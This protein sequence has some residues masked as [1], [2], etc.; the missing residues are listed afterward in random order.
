MQK[1]KNA[2]EANKASSPFD[3]FN[4]AKMSFDIIIFYKE[5]SKIPIH[6]VFFYFD[7]EGIESNIEVIKMAVLFDILCYLQTII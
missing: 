2:L 1:F 6:A 5:T 3:I 4:L 7:F